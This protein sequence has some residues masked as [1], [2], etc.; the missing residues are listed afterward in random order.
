[1]P[2]VVVVGAGVVGRAT[3]AGMTQLGH[4]VEYRDVDETVVDALRQRGAD[5]SFELDLR[6]PAAFV[7]LT[8]PTPTPDGRYDLTA[9]RSGTVAVAEALRDATE[10]H[11]VVVRSTVPP[12]TCENVVQPLLEEVSG[13]RLGV[14]LALASNPEFL[15]AR[16]ALEDFLHPWMTVVGSRDPATI[17]SLHDLY[18]P[19]RGEF[20][21]FADPAGAELAKC[22][23]NLYNAAKISFF[24]ELWRVA[25]ELGVE[26]DRVAETVAYSAEASFNPL[27]GIR[28]GAPFSG[29][30]LPKDVRGFLAFAEGLGIDM[31]VLR[32]VEEV[33]LEMRERTEPA[34]ADRL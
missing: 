29:S 13:C 8:L 9:L 3:G 10:A 20:R 15:R 30:C 27:Y 26:A 14:D 25:G 34:A 21:A 28:G 32:A 7:F 6:G 19:L 17:E 5:A 2:R 12:G 4:E 31:P 23:H 22:A 1:M 33:N 24:N 18:R 16:R 11:T